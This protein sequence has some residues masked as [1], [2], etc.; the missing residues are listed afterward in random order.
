MAEHNQIYQQAVYYDIIFDRDV[1]REVDFLLAVFREQTGRDATSVLDI[2]CGP[3]YHARAF[4]QRGLRATGLDLRPEMVA[5][6]R[7]KDAASGTHCTWLAADMRDF[8]L[9]APV[10][11]AFSM[12]DSVDALISDDDIVANMAAVARNLNPGGLYVL[13]YS[14]PRDSSLVGYRP[15][16]YEGQRD[17]LQVALSWVPGG[18]RFDLVN[19]FAR[20]TTELDVWQNGQPLVHIV[21]DACERLVMPHE[22][23]LLAQLSGVFDVVAWYGD[24]DTHQPLDDSERSVR[25][26]GVLK[27]RTTL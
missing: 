20:S 17:G 21:D 13:D 9:D 1:S 12:F 11:L 8:T 26:I 2:A 14:H 6:A 3:G 15:F 7:D 5:F 25:M 10:D 16:R 18:Q 24:Y 4:A 23:R 19:G 22:V 27:A